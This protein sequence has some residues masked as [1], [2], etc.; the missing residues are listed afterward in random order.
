MAYVVRQN[1]A[2][3]SESMKVS[4]KQV[5]EHHFGNHSDCGSWCRVRD[6]E[7]LE[8]EEADLKYRGK[9]TLVNNSTTTSG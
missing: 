4:I 9:K 7:G 6:L 8:R 3:D 2:K 5:T 1:C